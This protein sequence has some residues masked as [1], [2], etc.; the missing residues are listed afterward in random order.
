MISPSFSLMISSFLR[1]F[2]IFMGLFHRISASIWIFPSLSL[3][4]SL[5]HTHTHTLFLSL[6]SFFLIPSFFL[7][8]TFF[9]FSIFSAEKNVKCN[10]LR[11]SNSNVLEWHPNQSGESLF[12]QN[13]LKPVLTGLQK[14]YEMVFGGAVKQCKAGFNFGNEKKF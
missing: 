12:L 2:S 6:A 14:M 13:R 3:S 4:L 5:S 1:V 7:Y 9:L 10:F 11:Q 8:Y